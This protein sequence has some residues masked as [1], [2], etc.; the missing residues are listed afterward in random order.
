M[1]LNQPHLDRAL[2]CPSSTGGLRL[3]LRSPTSLPIKTAD[4]GKLTLG[5]LTAWCGSHSCFVVVWHVFVVWNGDHVDHAFTYHGPCKITCN[6]RKREA[7][8]FL[9]IFERSFSL[10]LIFRHIRETRNRNAHRSWFLRSRTVCIFVAHWVCLVHTIS[11]SWFRLLL[12]ICWERLISVLIGDKIKEVRGV[13]CEW[14][15][16]DSKEGGS[17]GLWPFQS[18]VYLSE[19]SWRMIRW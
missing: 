6:Q 7:N 5:E 12:N 19:S 15:A 2:S 8:F 16:E 3:M 14:K 10:H 1:P 17:C 9:K 4:S 13:S 18:W 11:F